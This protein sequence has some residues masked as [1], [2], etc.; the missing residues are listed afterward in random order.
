MTY[1]KWRTWSALSKS[2]EPL[3]RNRDPRMTQNGHVYTICCQSRTRRDVIS[4]RNVKCQEILKMQALAASE[5]I[6]K[7]SHWRRRWGCD[8]NA[9]CS[10][11][12]AAVDIISSVV[13]EI[14][15]DYHAVNLWAANFSSFWKK[16]KISPFCNECIDGRSTWAPFSGPRSKNI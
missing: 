6:K 14:F 10:P 12:K 5:K 8:V 3:W 11:S 16:I 4:G 2:I 15:W 7:K 9:I 13:A 1:R